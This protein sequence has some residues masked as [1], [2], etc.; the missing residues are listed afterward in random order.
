AEVYNNTISCTHADKCAGWPAM[1][2]T[3]GG[4]GLFY[5]NTIVNWSMWSWPMIFRVANSA[6]WVGGGFCKDTGTRKVCQDFAKHCT[7]GDRRACTQDSNCSSVG[8][9]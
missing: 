2:S 3:R 5:N 8:A 4:T 7:G 9:G 6:S 1:N